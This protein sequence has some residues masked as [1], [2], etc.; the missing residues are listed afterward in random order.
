MRSATPRSSWVSLLLNLVKHRR[1]I[2]LDVLAADR[3]GHLLKTVKKRIPAATYYPFATASCGCGFF[4][5][6]CSLSWGTVMLETSDAVKL[7]SC[8]GSFLCGGERHRI[9]PVSSK[10]SRTRLEEGMD[11]AGRPRD[12]PRELQRPGA[13]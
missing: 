9:L 3:F 10:A 11:P 4:F 5:P 2:S 8:P 7:S 1:A 6:L 13:K 12:L